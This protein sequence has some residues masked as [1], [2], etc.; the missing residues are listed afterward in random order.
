MESN[1]VRRYTNLEPV[2]LPSG[3]VSAP[4]VSAWRFTYLRNPAL[5]PRISIPRLF[6]EDTDAVGYM[7]HRRSS[8]IS[9]VIRCR[10]KFF[11]CIPRGVFLSGEWVRPIVAAC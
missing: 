2:D 8:Q 1:E 9:G 6:A 4:V 3:S 5:H 7:F 11:V 10:G